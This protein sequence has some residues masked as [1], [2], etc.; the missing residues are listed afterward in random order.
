MISLS[1]NKIIVGSLLDEYV[2]QKCSLKKIHVCTR[3]DWLG[4][5]NL[6]ICILPVSRSPYPYSVS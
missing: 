6:L 4:P 1:I 3:Q 2:G 5:Q